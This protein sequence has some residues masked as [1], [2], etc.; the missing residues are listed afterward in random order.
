MYVHAKWNTYYKYT[1][2]T[3]RIYDFI[4]LHSMLSYLSFS[5]QNIIS[6]FSV[7]AMILKKNTPSFSPFDTWNYFHIKFVPFLPVQI[8]SDANDQSVK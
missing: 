2:F 8:M 3:K 6:F 5:I 4:F 1:P 7:S